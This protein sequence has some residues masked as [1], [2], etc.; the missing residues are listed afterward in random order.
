MIQFALKCD[1]DHRFDSWFQSA[2]AFDK[3]RASGMLTCEICGSADVEKAMMAPRLG[4]THDTETAK[5]RPLSSPA[6]EAETALAQLRR[7]VEENSDYVGR[8]FAREAWRM[9]AGDAPERAIHG[10]AKPEEARKLLE[11]GV[12]IA[13]LP[14][15]P[16]RK[17]N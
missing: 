8:D 17:T 15:L 3:L 7:K 5:A 12:P 9:H 6:S 16:G 11:E 13:P 14:F 4:A 1:N 10:E 2:D